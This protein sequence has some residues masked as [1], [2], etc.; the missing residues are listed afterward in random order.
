MKKRILLFALTVAMSSMSLFAQQTYNHWSIQGKGGINTIRGVKTS[1]TERDFNAEYG[2]AIEYTF[3]PVMGIGVEYLYQNND[4]SNYNFTSNI[5][6]V[7]LF[8]SINVSNLAVQFRNDFWKNF[9][10][11]L[12]IGGGLGFGSYEN[13]DPLTVT[14]DRSGDITNL[15][16][17][18]GLNFEFNLGKAISLG[19]EPQFI[20]NSNGKYNPKVYQSTKDFY[21]VNL[22]LRYKI[23]S[24]K[25]H[26][27][28][29]NYAVYWLDQIENIKHQTQQEAGAKTKMQELLI[30]Q[31]KRDA[32]VKDS[33]RND[34]INRSKELEK[35][36][37]E[38]GV[39]F[40]KAGQNVGK[41]NL[42]DLNTDSTSSNSSTSTPIEQIIE[43]EPAI[44][45]QNPAAIEQP[46]IEPI[47]SETSENSLHS[48]QTVS[49]KTETYSGSELKRYSIVVGSFSSKAN[50]D[51]LADKLQSDETMA[52]VVQNDK[53]MY[54][55]ITH[56]SNG[57]DS[58]VSQVK[59]MRKDY[60]DAW[61][62]VLK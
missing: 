30:E 50:A 61:I 17:T 19:L 41:Q 24:S 4:H 26:I 34:S 49:M 35:K 13:S 32:F 39:F 20:W 15:A 27:R 21:S 5:S 33:L 31:A 40:K 12:N 14:T 59:K 46:M 3:T 54:R 28:N 36:N 9:N 7:T 60:P 38:D 11:Y 57:I 52:F 47:V 53:G 55:V 43:Q 8:T 44:T 51:K 58:A 48:K 6:Q 2:G 25:T 37:I 29:Q 18:A 56:T 42:S 22:N 62:L 23:G 1:A 16:V 10:T 45:E